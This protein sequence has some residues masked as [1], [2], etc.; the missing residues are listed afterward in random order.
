MKTPYSH[1]AGLEV[2][3]QSEL[4]DKQKYAYYSQEP[5]RANPY[6]DTSKIHYEP[7]PYEQPKSICGLRKRTFWIL[8]VVAIVVVAAAV[9]GGIGGALAVRSADKKESSPEAAGVSPAPTAVSSSASNPA[10]S[11]SA[12]VPRSSS[13]SATPTTSQGTIST[14]TLV[15]PTSTIFRD[16]PS[17]NDTV[18]ESSFG[19]AK[20]RKACG[21]SFNKDP[22]FN[23]DLV[24]VPVA[25]LD[26]CINLCAA[27]NVK[28]GSTQKCSA[29]CWRNTFDKVNDWPGGMCF[30]FTTKNVTANGQTSLNFALPAEARCDGA[31]MIS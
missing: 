8:I 18:F 9:G 10:A 28:S 25:S 16:C 31:A 21:V 15:G 17:S 11:S 29:V 22:D 7:P 24:A 14:T 13:L 20:W 1:H 27:Q 30:G 26:E 3:P 5:V 4:P 2:V 23:K 19:G 6:V 12:S